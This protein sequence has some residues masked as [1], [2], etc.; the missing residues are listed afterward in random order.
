MN[1]YHSIFISVVIIKCKYN[2]ED[3]MKMSF[4]Y[5]YLILRFA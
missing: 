4:G 1:S 2:N 3:L 5:S